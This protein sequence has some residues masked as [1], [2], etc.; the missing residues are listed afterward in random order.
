MHRFKTSAVWY[1]DFTSHLRLLLLPIAFPNPMKRL[2]LVSVSTV[3]M[4]AGLPSRP[5]ERVAGRAG[6]GPSVGLAPPATLM[7]AE[8]GVPYRVAGWQGVVTR[9][10]G[11]GPALADRI[12]ALSRARSRPVR[13][14]RSAAAS[15]KKAQKAAAG[16]VAHAGG[17][18]VPRQEGLYPVARH[19]TGLVYAKGFLAGAPV[20][21]V[22]ADLR[23]PEVKV[24]IVVARG[25]IGR[26][27]SFLSL[28]NRTTPGA[29]I[30]G[31]F[32]GLRNG[33]PTGD[34]VV[35]G[36]AIFRGFIGTALAITDGNVVSFISTGYNEETHW[37]LFDT[38]VRGGP[39]LVQAGEMAVNPREEGFRSL[40]GDAYRARTAVGITADRKLLLVAIRTGVTLRRLAMVM[41]AL[42]AYHAV[43]LDG[44][45]STAMSFGGR[46][47]AQ[48]GRGLTN[49]LVVYADR[50]RY[51]RA[52]DHFYYQARRR[53]LPAGVPDFGVEAPAAAGVAT[54]VAGDA[55]VVPSTKD[56]G[57]TAPNPDGPAVP[58]AAGTERP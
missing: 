38:V 49:L 9:G 15:D 58:G 56:P 32:F 10:P 48:P 1:N 11:A 44:G 34:L 57:E 42:G 6:G 41:R 39:R 43:A 29:A 27:E 54:P 4:L 28:L 25:G 24:G 3:V 8:A 17:V 2:I 13:R 16:V 18:S 5:V 23:D 45:T 50:G 19:G 40:A 53:V 55:K 21:V 22:Q 7:A 51:E 36:R 46:V 35:N 33:L 30:T 26:S 31:T 52:R 20:H 14:A 47:V 12:D 37:E